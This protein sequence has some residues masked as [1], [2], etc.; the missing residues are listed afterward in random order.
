[1]KGFSAA[2]V[3]TQLLLTRVQT[4]Y[5]RKMF[6]DNTHVESYANALLSG[7]SDGK[8]AKLISYMYNTDAK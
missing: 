8:K 3:A 7:R 1:M 6:E 2:R 4:R 5:E